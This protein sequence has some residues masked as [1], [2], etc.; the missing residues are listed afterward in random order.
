MRITSGVCFVLGLVLSL[1]A[2]ADA[3]ADI[4]AALQHIRGLTVTQGAQA[5]AAANQALDADWKVLSA[6]KAAALPVMRSQYQ[7]E[8]AAKAPSQFFL[9]DIGYFLYGDGVASDKAMALQGLMRLDTTSPIIQANTQELFNFAYAATRDHQPG[10]TA[11]VDR[12]FLPGQNHVYVP[13]HALDLDPTLQCVFL[14]G[15]MG[16]DMETHLDDLLGQ[17]VQMQRVLEVLNWLGTE[18]SIPAATIVLKAHPND[19]VFQRL[20]GYFMGVGGP[21][22][23]QSLLDLDKAGLS[24][25]SRAGYS[26][27]EPAVKAQDYPAML[28]ELQSL[29]PGEQIE[30]AAMR[31]RLDAMVA[32]D[33]RDD[34]MAPASILMSTLPTDE[35]LSRMLVVRASMFN[36][37]SDE[38]LDDVEITNHIIDAL[39]YRRASE[40]KH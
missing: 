40:K 28:T 27:L 31:A 33:G 39:Q 34:A 4:Q 20:V 36:R 14:Y 35:L 17:G 23:R 15:V 29:G 22:G 9:L 21:T 30:D 2:R 5:T 24:E 7:A 12:V 26:K 8:L 11:F 25:V 10:M 37:L 6:N 32:H 1:P 13:Q 19:A 3:E 38:A 18:R 16:P